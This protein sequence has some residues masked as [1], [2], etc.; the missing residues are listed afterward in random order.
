MMLYLSQ[1]SFNWVIWVAMAFLIGGGRLQHPPVILPER[2][3]FRHR[4]WLGLACLA[5]FVATFV[6]IPFAQ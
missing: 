5:V 1:F 3:I 4:A 2:S 6:P